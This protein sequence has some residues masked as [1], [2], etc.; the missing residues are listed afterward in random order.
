LSQVSFVRLYIDSFLDNSIK[1]KVL[2]TLNGLPKG[3]KALDNAYNDAIK[4]IE[5]Q[6]P[7]NS[8]LARSILSWITYAQRPLTTGELSHALAVDIGDS[9]LDPGNIPEVEDMVSVCVGL[10]TV[11]D[12]TN[13]IRLVHYTTQEYFVRIRED[14]Y[15]RAQQEIT[16]TRLTYLSFDPFRAGSCPDD[17]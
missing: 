1:K 17:G 3:S 14:W 12:E 6:L 8:A 4:R 13:I 9:E 7:G 11:D 5:G 15:P 10:V 16:L 2:S